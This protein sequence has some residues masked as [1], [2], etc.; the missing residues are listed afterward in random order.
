MITGSDA[1]RVDQAFAFTLTFV[2]FW[3]Q[4]WKPENI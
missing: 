4:V 3:V 1:I 2:L